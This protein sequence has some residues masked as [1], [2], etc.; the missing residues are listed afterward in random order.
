MGANVSDF[1]MR[2]LTAESP[3]NARH[4]RD[5]GEG[6]S[7]RVTCESP[8]YRPVGD[9]LPRVWLDSATSW[10]ASVVTPDPG[11]VYVN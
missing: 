10:R 3:E 9:L 5:R 8:V 6:M 2:I 11:I 4:E 7:M 1:G